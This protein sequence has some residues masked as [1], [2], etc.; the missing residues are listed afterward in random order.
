MYEQIFKLQA[1]TLK[2]LAHSRRLEIIQLLGDQELPV[3][4]IYQMLDLPQANVSQHLMV[5]KVSKVLKTRKD[6]KQI[7]YKVADRLFFKL[8]GL[9]RSFLVQQYIN[10]E[11]A[12]EFTLHMN[13]LVP[14]THD[15]VCKM[16]VSP[17]TASFAYKYHNHDYYFCA[18]GCLKKF[19]KTPKKYV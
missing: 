5:L 14:I 12:D 17:K 6:G 8:L 3:T 9:L 4:A 18:S 19:K 7:Y 15:P 10:T 1:K 11:L 2:A 13:E 16:R